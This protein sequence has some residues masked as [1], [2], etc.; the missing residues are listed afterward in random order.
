MNP[1]LAKGLQAACKE[2]LKNPNIDRGVQ[3]RHDA[4]EVRQHVL[5]VFVNLQRGRASAC[6]SRTKSCGR[7]RAPN[8]SCRT[9]PPTATYL[10]SWY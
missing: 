3:R 5:R 1:A 9:T 7:T 10:A 2:Y 6:W 8:H 4:R